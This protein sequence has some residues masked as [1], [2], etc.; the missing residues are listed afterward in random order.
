MAETRATLERLRPLMR[1]GNEEILS[2]W[3]R[4]FKNAG[5]C[6]LAKENFEAAGRH[7]DAAADWY[8]RAFAVRQGHYP[9]ANLAT[10][11]LLR[12]AVALRLDGHQR[13]AEAQDRHAKSRESAAAIL[14]DRQRKPWPVDWE[15]DDVWHPA[16]LG[17]LR[18]L[19]QA[20]Q[21]AAEQYQTALRAPHARPFHARSMR[22]Q[23]ERVVRAFETLGIDVLPPFSGS[24]QLDSLFHLASSDRTN[25]T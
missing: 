17:E 8:A 15:D 11:W 24:E 18:L 21:P 10:L 19:L 5:D 6:A 4:L 16:T 9:G 3:G 7:Y 13:S 22:Q 25:A 12:A 1:A 23:V 2:R 20:W 14:S